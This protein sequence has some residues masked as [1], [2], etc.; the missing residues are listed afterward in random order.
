MSL[1][2]IFSFRTINVWI[3]RRREILDL[4]L[5]AWDVIFDK[6]YTGKLSRNK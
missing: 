3:L 2:N 4:L 6:N 5:L 1:K